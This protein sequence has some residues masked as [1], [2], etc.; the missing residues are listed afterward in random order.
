MILPL[1]NKITEENNA[2]LQEISKFNDNFAK[3]QA[4]QMPCTEDKNV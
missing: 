3:I 2:M 4:E 1:Q